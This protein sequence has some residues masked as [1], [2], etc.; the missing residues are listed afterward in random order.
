MN[1]KYPVNSSVIEDTLPK[2][3]PKITTLKEDAEKLGYKV[4]KK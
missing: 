2:E 3:D 4:E 1:G